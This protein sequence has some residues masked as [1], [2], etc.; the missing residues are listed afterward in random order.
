MTTLY[1]DKTKE[2]LKFLLGNFEGLKID[3]KKAFVEFLESQEDAT[4]ETVDLPG[5]RDSIQREEAKIDSFTYLK[6]LG[7]E[8]S[9]DGHIK[10]LRRAKSSRNLDIFTL[11]FGLLLSICLPFAIGIM[12]E[13][14]TSGIVDEKLMNNATLL[15]PVSIVGILLA[16]KGASR[17]DA[18]KGFRL[19]GQSTRLAFYKKDQLIY[20]TTD[21]SDLQVMEKGEDMELVLKE[22]DK[23]NH[24]IITAHKPNIYFQQTIFR[25]RDQFLN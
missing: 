14:S 3:R 10:V 5:L 9:D 7:F 18:F 11:V 4:G 6:N 21:L 20:E 17:I 23:R 1:Q 2:E 13:A 16:Y 22:S 12:V 25:L 19:E 8:L 15:I 24:S